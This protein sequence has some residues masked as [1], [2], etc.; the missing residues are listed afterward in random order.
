MLEAQ[1][2][3]SDSHFDALKDR[4]DALESAGNAYTTA[5]FNAAKEAS[6]QYLDAEIKRVVDDAKAKVDVY[7][8]ELVYYEDVVATLGDFDASANVGWAI[9]LNIIDPVAYFGGLAGYA[10]DATQAYNNVTANNGVANRKTQAETDIATAEA[11]NEL[12]RD[13]AFDEI[14]TAYTNAEN[15]AWNIYYV[16]AVAAD[17][18]YLA[19]Y[20]QIE[21]TFAN[22][23]KNA[24]AA[25]MSVVVPAWGN[26]VGKVK[27]YDAQFLTAIAHASDANFNV[28]DWFDNGSG[29][30]NQGDYQQVTMMT[31][32]SMPGGGGQ[33]GGNSGQGGTLLNFDGPQHEETWGEA[34]WQLP[35]GIFWGVCGTIKEIAMVGCDDAR[36]LLYIG[37]DRVGAKDWDVDHFQPWSRSGA[38]LMAG[39]FVY[40]GISPEDYRSKV[41]ENAA[42]LGVASQLDAVFEYNYRDMSK[43][44]MLNQVGTVF[45]FQAAPIIVTRFGARTPA[46]VTPEP[47]V[48][49]NPAT[50][51]IIPYANGAFDIGIFPGVSRGLV[52]SEVA[53]ASNPTWTVNSAYVYGGTNSLAVTQARLAGQINKLSLGI[54][55][56]TGFSKAEMGT[57]LRL[58]QILGKQ[59]TRDATGAADWIDI[60]GKTYDACGAGYK[61]PGFR[62][63]Q[64][65]RSLNRHLQKSIDYTVIDLT[66][67][68]PVMRIQI[69]DFYKALHHTERMKIIIITGE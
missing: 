13:A 9:K 67:C 39:P 31:T 56:Q 2:D 28:N 6:L 14:E 7:K 26:Y 19:K 63:D 5:T 34:L 69:L 37:M 27:K 45:A 65:L 62:M 25:F 21:T 49:P 42:S 68:P 18:T 58:E 10:A 47:F 33:G 12:V 20:A 30:T 44:D 59:L 57:A 52:T 51:G 38:A 41:I 29:S 23:K 35:S 55:P 66:D 43:S 15:A 3:R 40:G 16:K 64:Y 61:N 22:A 48:P 46:P 54:D 8:A 24:D 32:G 1:I 11:A 53:I 50:S 17:V 60:N 4:Y 36:G